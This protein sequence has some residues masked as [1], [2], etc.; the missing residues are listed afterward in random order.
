MMKLITY[1]GFVSLSSE[2]HG[3]NVLIYICTNCKML[4]SFREF[5]HI[6]IIKNPMMLDNR[7]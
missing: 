6:R 5:F 2:L 3:T 1:K 4:S 7:S